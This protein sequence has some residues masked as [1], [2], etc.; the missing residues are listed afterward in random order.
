VIDQAN[1]GP[2]ERACYHAEIE[3]ARVN[4]V[5]ITEFS[6]DMDALQRW[7]QHA[8][9]ESELA[10]SVFVNVRVWNFYKRYPEP[11]ILA[12]VSGVFDKL[13]GATEL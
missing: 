9:A 13:R 4:A 1:P 2:L 11:A 7:L 3:W 6:D 8:F 10:D 5:R 12:F